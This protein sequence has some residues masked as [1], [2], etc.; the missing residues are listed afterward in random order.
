MVLFNN[1]RRS[2]EMRRDKEKREKRGE[3]RGEVDK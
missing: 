3:E 1:L 2:K